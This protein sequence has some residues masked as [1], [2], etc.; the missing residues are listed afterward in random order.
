MALLDAERG[1]ESAE[2]FDQLV[3]SSPN[4]SIIWIQYMAFHLHSAEVD[5]ARGVA[6]RAIKTISFREEQEKLNVWVAL[7]NLENSYGTKDTLDKTFEEAVKV[8]EPKKIFLKMADIYSKSE[9]KEVIE[10]FRDSESL[11]SFTA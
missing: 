9:K 3:L 1:P 7:L 6:Q 10:I 2:D 4:S 8:N 11:R 5:K